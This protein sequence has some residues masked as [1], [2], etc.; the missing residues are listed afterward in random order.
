MRKHVCAEVQNKPREVLILRCMELNLNVHELHYNTNE[1]LGQSFS[2]ELQWLSTKT[3]KQGS[4]GIGVREWWGQLEKAV[5]PG[6]LCP[7]KSFILLLLLSFTSAR[8]PLSPPNLVWR[9]A[10]HIHISPLFLS[11]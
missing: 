5:T 1:S 11:N 2:A 4:L 9:T 6:V 8:A 3:S 7:L 10:L